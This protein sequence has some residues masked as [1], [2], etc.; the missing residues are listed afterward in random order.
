MICTACPV[1]WNT[2]D[3]DNGKSHKCKAEDLPPRGKQYHPVRGMEDLN[4]R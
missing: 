4:E 3:A 1:T 2:E